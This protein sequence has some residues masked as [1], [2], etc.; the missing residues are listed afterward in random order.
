MPLDERDPAMAAYTI[1]YVQVDDEVERTVASDFDPICNT[2][3]ANCFI[4][5]WIVIH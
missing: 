3:H 4:N 2:V 5:K 1:I